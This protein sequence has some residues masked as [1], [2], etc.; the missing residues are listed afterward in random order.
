MLEFWKIVLPYFAPLFKEVDQMSSSQRISNDFTPPMSSTK[1]HN[2]VDV[3]Q[4]DNSVSEASDYS[5]NS[6]T[7]IF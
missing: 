1:F 4:D 6:S 2:D 3:L 7:V 5:G